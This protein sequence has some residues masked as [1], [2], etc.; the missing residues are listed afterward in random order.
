MV[1]TKLELTW[2]GKD[3]RPKLEPRILLENQIWGQVFQPFIFMSVLIGLS[4]DSRISKGSNI[5]IPNIKASKG[6]DFNTAT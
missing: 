3:K 5:K 2:I 4:A 6:S 1:K